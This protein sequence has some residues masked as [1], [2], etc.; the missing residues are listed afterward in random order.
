MGKAITGTARLAAYGSTRYSSKGSTRKAPRLKAYGTVLGSTTIGNVAGAYAGRA[1]GG[2]GGSK[3]GA[4]VGALAGMQAGKRIAA[5]RG[6]IHRTKQRATLRKVHS[7]YGQA[8][9][10]FHQSRAYHGH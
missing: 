1:V 8:D 7:T 4:Q 9:A 10:A 3:V 2:V 6:Y 5:K